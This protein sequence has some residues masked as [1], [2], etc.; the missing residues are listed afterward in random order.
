MVW[1]SGEDGPAQTCDDDH[2]LSRNTYG[3]AQTLEDVDEVSGLF[4]I[5][6]GPGQTQDKAT[7]LSRIPQ[8]KVGEET[9]V[10]AAQGHALKIG[11]ETRAETAAAPHVVV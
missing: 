10:A 3:P 7:G 4:R 2:G 6:Y 11:V 1:I 8:E 9:M 5:T